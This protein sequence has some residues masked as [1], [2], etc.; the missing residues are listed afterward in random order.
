VA[1]RSRPAKR[2]GRSALRARLIPNPDPSQTNRAARTT[3]RRYEARSLSLG[4]RWIPAANCVCLR[5]QDTSLHSWRRCVILRDAQ[6]D[7]VES[8][9]DKAGEERETQGAA[10]ALGRSR[11]PSGV[12]QLFQR[13][14]DS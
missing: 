5:P 9:R 2:S 12:A 4:Q 1:T 7:P 6:T 10:E 11:R 14:P 8:P 3:A 13:E